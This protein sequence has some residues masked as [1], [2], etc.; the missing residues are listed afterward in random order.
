MNRPPRKYYIASKL[1]NVDQVRAVKG[2]LDAAGWHHTYDWTVHGSVQTCGTERIA[3]VAKAEARGVMKADVV[4]VL[5]P[6]GRGTHVEI[7]LALA[8][9]W[10]CGEC[11]TDED[12]T[13]C[14][15]SLNPEEDFGTAG[16]TCAFYHYP[17]VQ[18]FTD[19]DEMIGY[20]LSE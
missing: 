19:L 3:E 12:I 18:K 7:G 4:V 2:M 14:L 17:G 20:L 8:N 6:G 11:A 15:Y 16:K 1:E 10:A 5:L 9:L 13:I